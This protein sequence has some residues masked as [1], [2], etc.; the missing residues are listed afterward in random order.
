M[1]R[2]MKTTL[3]VTDFDLEVALIKRLYAISAHSMSMF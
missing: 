1:T 3:K 2:F